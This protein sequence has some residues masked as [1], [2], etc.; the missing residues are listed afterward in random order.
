[1]HRRSPSAVGPGV[2]VRGH[3]PRHVFGSDFASS[4]F[5]FS[6][7]FCAS[8]ASDLMAAW[9]FCLLFFFLCRLG[10]D[11]NPS[12]PVFFNVL[13]PVTEPVLDFSS[14]L[15]SLMFLL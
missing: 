1:M 14:S 3:A 12:M 4:S 10:M 9:F 8:L 11:P 7:P 15:Y 6:G 13:V 5:F 2:T